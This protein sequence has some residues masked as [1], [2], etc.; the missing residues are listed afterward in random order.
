MWERFLA[1]LFAARR[2][3]DA[4]VLSVFDGSCYSL[5]LYDVVWSTNMKFVAVSQ[6][7]RRLVRAGKLE[8]I[9]FSWLPA[10]RQLRWRLKN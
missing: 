5:D 10:G 3:R 7:L 4:K 9:D 2:E 6:S 1:W 8:I